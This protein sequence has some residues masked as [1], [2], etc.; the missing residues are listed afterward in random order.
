MKFLYNNIFIM[1]QVDK[2]SAADTVDLGSINGLVKTKLEKRLHLH[3]ASLLVIS[4][5]MGSMKL[6]RV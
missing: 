5:K 2:S 4:N 1:S 6:H 3:P